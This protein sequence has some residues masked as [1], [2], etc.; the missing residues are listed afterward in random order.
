LGVFFVS[1]HTN[2]T[3]YPQVIHN[4][5][6]TFQEPQDKGHFLMVWMDNCGIYGKSP[7]FA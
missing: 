1:I 4:L 7:D 3:S 6:I 5:W 2:S